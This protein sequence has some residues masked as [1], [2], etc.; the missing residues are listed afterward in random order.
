M[1]AVDL[2]FEL[3][4]QEVASIERDPAGNAAAGIADNAA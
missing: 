1:F 2:G 4:L 3:G